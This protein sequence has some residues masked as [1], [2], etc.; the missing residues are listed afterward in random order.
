VCNEQPNWRSSHALVSVSLVLG[1]L[2]T[3]LNPLVRL[4]TVALKKQ[5]WEEMCSSWWWYGRSQTCQ[6]AAKRSLFPL[7][8]PSHTISPLPPWEGESEEGEKEVTS[9]WTTACLGLLKAHK[10]LPSGASSWCC[11]PPACR[12]APASGFLPPGR[13]AESAGRR[14]STGPGARREREGER[15]GERR[16]TR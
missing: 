4:G 1:Y 5:R 16:G 8:A 13:R 15:E 10:S 2:K 11:R 7:P 9:T 3:T 12:T 6:Q 14:A